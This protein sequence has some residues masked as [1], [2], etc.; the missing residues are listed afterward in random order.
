MASGRDDA[1]P[2]TD[3]V[4][5]VVARQVIVGLGHEV[6]GFELLHRPTPG[7][8]EGAQGVDETVPPAAVLG[9]A[10]YDV[11]SLVSRTRLYCKPWP[12]LLTGTD[13]V[14]PPAR[15]T[16]LEVP[17]DLCSEPDV[18]DRCR[19]L[20]EDGWALAV[21][22]TTWHDGI[23][24]LLGIAEMVRVDVASL[25]RERVH[26]LVALSRNYHVALLAAQC[27]TE[28]DVTWSRQAGFELFQGPAV[29][30]PVE[31]TGGRL[32]PS[33][34]AQVQLATELL[35]ERLD[36]ARVEQILSHEPALVVQVLE[37]ASRG[38]AG[39]LRR[40]VRSIREALVYL[41]TTRLRQWAAM[42]VLGRN[43]ENSR[44]DALMTALTRARTCALL[45]PAHGID[46]GYAF[47]AGLLSTLDRLLGVPIAEVARK[48]DVDRDLAVAAFARHG[49]V[50][51]LVRRVA[52]YQDS[53]SAGIPVLLAAEDMRDMDLAAAQAFAWAMDHVN[54]MERYPEDA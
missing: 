52:D 54:A 31:V 28:A 44:G 35:D 18:V 49:Q 6:V 24:S 32:A 38:A 37:E 51:E 50:G 10:E 5:R 20:L 46:R 26:D 4:D 9:Q 17:A 47:T 39:G 2:T 7:A 14:L 11:E 43:A 1:T 42:V 30:R 16:V 34:L 40:E 8:E 27:L 45:A 15:R 23:G 36:F 19:A 33:A 12:G 3:T 22:L 29:Q 48:V 21:D 13:P 41:G 25:S 53:I